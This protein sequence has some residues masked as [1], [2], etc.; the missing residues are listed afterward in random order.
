MELVPCAR[1]LLA[2]QRKFGESPQHRWQQQQQPA[3]QRKPHLVAVLRK[4]YGTGPKKDGV[5]SHA[6]EYTVACHLEDAL[7]LQ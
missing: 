5:P 7:N 2:A 1:V 4:H 6:A 3:Q